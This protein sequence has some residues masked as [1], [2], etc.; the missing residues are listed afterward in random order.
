[1][2]REEKLQQEQRG[3]NRAPTQPKGNKHKLLRMKKQQ[4][5]IQSYPPLK[6][7]TCYQ[8]KGIR[9]CGRFG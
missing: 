4:Q 1:M 8:H 6:N 3:G 2:P 9:W 7:G 5:P